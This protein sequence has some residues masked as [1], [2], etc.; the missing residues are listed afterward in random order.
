GWEP[1][2]GKGLSIGANL[3]YY[4]GS[5]DRSAETNID[6]VMDP[7]KIYRTIQSVS[8]YQ[9]GKL[10]AEIGAIYSLKLKNNK[11]LN[12]GLTYQP[13]MNITVDQ[14]KD[15]TSFSE[16]SSDSIYSASSKTKLVLPQK[17]SAGISYG[18]PKLE[19]SLDYIYQNFE[20]AYQ[21]AAAE[22]NISLTKYQDIRMG[23]S[24]TPNRYDIRSAMKR[25]T[26]RAG[27]RYGN[28]YMTVNGKKIDDYSLTIGVG[29]PLQQN[30]LTH[31]NLGFDVGRRGSIKNTFVQETYFRIY[32]GVNLFVTQEWFV[33]HKFK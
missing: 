27:L 14:S 6:P 4:H 9:F 12:F 16:V 18:S 10:N 30:G 1:F 3:L 32:L 11:T 21:I 28:S 24:Y 8:T 26:Y 23:L 25:W 20:N 2:I 15:I 31:M 33:R 22:S 7:T 29:V 13:K 17:F 5:I 19:F